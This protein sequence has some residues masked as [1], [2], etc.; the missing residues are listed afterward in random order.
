MLY[1]LIAILAGVAIVVSRIINSNLAVKIGL[2]QSTFYNFL[3][4]LLFSTII[5][6]ISRES[7]NISLNSIPFLAYLGG[8]IGVIS[9]SISNHVAQKISAFYMALL[10][11]I[12]QL[13]I[14][15]FIDYFSLN[16]LS[17]GKVIGGIIVVIGLGYNLLVDKKEAESKAN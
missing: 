2:F 13:F 5:L 1:I 4:G 16:Q 11:F 17:L 3:T 14:G 8:L 10:I 7:L 12:G 9:I 15:I 6:V